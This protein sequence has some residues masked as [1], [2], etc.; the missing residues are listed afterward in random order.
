MASQHAHYRY[1]VTIRTDD[2]ALLGCFRALSQHCQ[3]SGNVRIPSGGTKDEDWER[4]D[5][6]VTFRFTRPR[7]RQ[8]FVEQANRIFPH[9]L[10]QEVGRSDNDPAIPQS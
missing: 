9:E 3:H 6:R 4:D 2:H 5:H 8:D 1:S 10:W 7:Y